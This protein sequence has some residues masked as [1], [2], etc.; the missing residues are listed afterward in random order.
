MID[1]IAKQTCH[2]AAQTQM[3]IDAK[4]GCFALDPITTVNHDSKN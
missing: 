2:E 3:G 1:V 4:I